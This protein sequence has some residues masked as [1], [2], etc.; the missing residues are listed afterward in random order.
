MFV[1]EAA[2]PKA[3]KYF[4]YR[5]PSTG[6]HPH[7]YAFENKDR[8]D[9]ALI[10]PFAHFIRSG[11]PAGPWKS[12]VILPR[13]AA[14]D[15][16]AAQGM[17]VGLHVHF[18]YPELCAELLTLISANRSRCDLILTTNTARKARA[19]EKETAGYRR[20]DVQITTIPNR[21]R[22]I[23]AF[24]TGL[25]ETAK[26]YDVIGHLHSKRSLFLT[27]RAIGERW[28]NFIWTNLIGR[29]HPMM[30]VVLDAFAKDGQLG[31]VF[32]DD[33]H[34]SAWDEN[35]EIAQEL[36][37]RMGLKRQLPPFFNF[38]LGTMFW[39]RTEAL[40]PLFTL[41]LDWD[42]YPA[43]PVPIDGTIL[44]ALE[45]LLPFAAEHQGYRHA[46]THIPG[47]TW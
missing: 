34:L 33:P 27:D 8:Y 43:E 6:F 13:A 24:L 25:G 37:N 35:L 7:V 31:L 29:E 15:P 39:A 41:G 20:G 10:N 46:T 36:A 32:P 5:R 12:D 2:I 17:K 47:V 3:G 38:P 14:G 28:R 16:I 21:G 45:R 40:A 19:L 44:H 11:K 4:H 1:A 42:S 22:D 18:H 26:H 30:D 9:A 23:G